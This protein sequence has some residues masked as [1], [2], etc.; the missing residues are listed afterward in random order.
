MAFPGS[1]YAP[2]GVYTQ[3]LY[4]D[5]N[6]GLAATVTLPLLLGTG[7]ET[8]VQMG[9]LMVR[10]S[11]STVDQRIVQEDESGR[12]VVS[13]SDAG[14]VTHGAF[15]GSLDRLQVRHYPIVSGDGTGT[16]ATDAASVS[17]TVNGEPVVVLAIT[18]ATGIL[19]L[20]VTP[21]ATDDVRVTYYFNRTDTLITDT[22]SEQ[23][24][25]DGPEVLGTANEPYIITTGA[26]DEL[27]FL[28]DSADEVEV[29]ISASPGAG[30]SAAQIASAINSASSIAGSSL[31]ATTTVDNYGSTVVRL[32]ADRDIYV[33]SGSANTR[34]GLTAGTD[35]A[36]T[37]VFYTFQRPIVDGTNEGAA[38]TDPADVTVKVDGVQ[39][40]PSALDGQT[41]AVTL[42]FAPEAGA[43]VTCQYYFNSWQDTFDYLAHRNITDIF[44]CGVTD[45]RFDWIEGADF[46]LEDDLIVW[47]SAVLV[48]AGEHTAGA[49]YLDGTQVSG[50]LVDTRQYLAECSPVV[51]TS[52]TPAVENRVDWSL[53]LVPTTG[54][55][56]STPLAASTF[57]EISNGRVDLATNR[58]DL[59][60]AYWGYDMQDALDRGRVTVTKVD[61]V[62][63]R[64]TLEQPVPVGASVWA[65]FYYNT[66]QDQTYTVTVGTEGGSGSGT[67]TLTDADGNTVFTP[68]FTA[69][70]AG[71]A[72]VTIQ[73]PSGS[74]ATPD[75][76]FEP[77]FVQTSYT[78]PVEE[79]ITVEFAA[80]DATL[81][82]YTV[83]G[84][85]PYYLIDNN[86]DQMDVEI[87]GAAITGGEV[88]LGD[89]TGHG[90]GFAATVTGDEIT[91]EAASGGT[92]FTI[93]STNSTL[94]FQ[95]D[96]TSGTEGVINAIANQG[97]AQTAADYCT[98][99]NRAT[100]GDF[101]TFQ[102][103]STATALIL[104]A[105]SSDV[106]D[107]YVGWQIRIT[108]DGGATG[109][110][111]EVATVTAYTAATQTATVAAIA[112]APSLGD[113][114]HIYD[115][116]TT[117]S[118][119][120]TTRFLTGYTVAAGEYDQLDFTY[121]GSVT[122]GAGVLSATLTPG[123]YATSALLAA[124][125]ETQM[126][127]ALAAAGTMSN[128]ATAA[129]V[130]VQAD[131]SGRLQVSLIVDAT[132]T[133]GGF[134]EFLASAGGA[135]SD[136]AILAGIDT[137]AAPQGA[138]A[139]LVNSD[140]A[141]RFTITAPTTG[142]LLNDRII[143]RN[144][145][146]PGQGGSEDGQQVLDQCYLEIL[147]GTGATLAGL[148]AGEKGWAGIRGSVM[149]PTLSSQIGF[150][151]GQITGVG[152]ASD[153]MPSITFFGPGG[154][155]PQNNVFKFNWEGETLTITFTDILGGT[156]GTAASADLPLGP[157]S[158]AN[159][160]INQIQAAMTGAGLAGFTQEGAGL[161]LRGS[162]S[163]A[164]DTIVIQDGNANDALGFSEGDMAEVTPLPAE[165]LVSGLM[166]NSNPGAPANAILQWLTGGG[167][168]GQFTMVALAKTVQN[169]LGADFLFLQSI[170]N[171]G[172]LGLATSVIFDDAAVASV[173]RPG[174]G[175]G[176]ESGDGNTGEAAVEGFF[177]TSSDGVNGSGTA[178][179][180]VLNT[181]TGQDG[182]VGATYRD[183]VT[184]FT[185]T[186][187]PREGSAAYPAGA[188]LT[189][190]VR[191]TVTTDSNVPVNSVPGI[192]LMVA[193]TVGCAVGDTAEVQ[194]YEKG[195][196]SPGIGDTY[197][198]SYEYSKQDFAP[199]LFTK[200]QSVV[201]AYG[202]MNPNNPVSL[203]GY[204]CLL[205]GAVVM[206][207]KQVQKDVDSDSD[208]V[209]DSASYANWID[210]ID[211]VEGSL[212][213]GAYPNILVPLKGD[214]LELF[215]YM[216]KHCDIQSSIR[217]RAE[218]T[219]LSGFGAG[220]QARQAGDWS[221]AV[222][223]T[224]LRLVYP[225]IVTLSMSRAD[226]TTDSYL[227]DGTYLAAALAGNRAAASI[228]V[229][230]PWTNAR[231]FGFDTLGRTQDAVE[232]NQT[233]VKGISVI[234]QA[235]AI[236]K[237]RHGLTTD[238]SNVLTKTPTVVTIADEVQ[239]QARATLDRFIGVKF[240]NGVTS[241]IES[242]LS[243]TLKSLVQLQ[244]IAAYTGVT[245]NTAADDPT[246]AEVEAFY[247][248]VF[249]LLY[250]VVTFNLRSSL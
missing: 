72:T 219:C 216:A 181:G 218:R 53:P 107:Y 154:T 39:V 198:V 100:L 182:T 159:T 206:A 239:R 161:R 99:V 82:K 233:A 130:T 55:G 166:A 225:D 11:S 170:A 135:A 214:S 227:V 210:A 195:G 203:A 57:A 119:K 188:T 153:G 67:Y 248:P 60:Y 187:L 8:L 229:A 240:L 115:P 37:K 250:I 124:E 25:P 202:P 123:G 138:Q 215:N 121:T 136:F 193:N 23:V 158:V 155:T 172:T 105:G 141:R 116:D 212:P 125:V 97:A 217:Y 127:A 152:D 83:P 21:E 167:G 149:Q 33:D 6:V 128:P 65:T 160:V 177:V 84:S 2:P 197:Y 244:I 157:A 108:S 243:L 113:D 79:N 27:K 47:G 102:A 66:L 93:D 19:R 59:V 88:D 150:G 114:Y 32:T 173:T 222:A 26:D 180:S 151:G 234:E 9:L 10:G 17:V 90:T 228:D 69:K 238:M 3:T 191:S 48:R 147:G 148:Q 237:V 232:K 190:Q 192:E 58:P 42:P 179:T 133:Q 142:A 16:T 242:Q 87:D 213:G 156:I 45:D 28:V 223:R 200:L 211:D 98:A 43:V 74:E 96:S 38:S 207:V 62:A 68:Q 126:N 24:S 145:L 70:S 118:V 205:N 183:A 92:T 201:N 51:D 110:L 209:L 35:T 184:G 221:Q 80:Q 64:M 204:L 103:G 54:N 94:D 139:K 7:S 112:G 52:G 15:D 174:T 245:A 1:I 165:V 44:Q 111:N 71:L 91:Y 230:T 76:R 226:G 36:R 129:Q 246:V 194:T 85:A 49:T 131:T 176:V 61:G 140:V 77:P 178:N 175:L 220:I 231:L 18:G 137:D 5:P 247:Q 236:L 169:E 78:G 104:G 81:A 189:F 86:S 171:G 89:P 196:E 31:A 13:I 109:C 235:G 14:A 40:I 241:Q 199:K 41:G 101:D 162:G 185:F 163:T 20:S 95:I 143:L 63:G 132:D 122:T 12:A 106:D 46:V 29:T 208:G 22:L 224:R 144:R 4:E 56:R 120:S 34:L 134:L 117:P 73:F 146:I 50:T 30:W 249:P 75:C 168:A 186:V 164:A